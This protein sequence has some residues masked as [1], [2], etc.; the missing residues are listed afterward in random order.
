MKK[1][2]VCM[3]LLSSASL[4]AGLSA[5]IWGHTGLAPMAAQLN[6]SM[7][8][9]DGLL[10]A[11]PLGEADTPGLSAVL[12]DRAADVRTNLQTLAAGIDGV[13]DGL[14]QDKRQMLLNDYC[15]FMVEIR[16]LKTAAEGRFLD[17]VSLELGQTY[18]QHGMGAFIWGNKYGLVVP[19]LRDIQPDPVQP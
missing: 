1:L 10:K 9:V 11:N 8:S 14:A 17:E 16:D 15:V 18:Q 2:L 5:F 7:A 4:M 3:L 19:P 12:L 13:M 6:G